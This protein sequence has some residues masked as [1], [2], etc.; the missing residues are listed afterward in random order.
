MIKVPQ[1]LDLSHNSLRVNQILKCIVNFL[2]RHL[3]V[4]LLVYCRDHDSI[5]ASTNKLYVLK[6]RVYNELSA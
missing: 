4:I 2:D 5:G 6:V 1:Q 3:H